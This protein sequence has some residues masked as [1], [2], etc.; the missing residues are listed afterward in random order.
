MLTTLIVILV[1]AVIG[2]LIVSVL[3][4]DASAKRIAYVLV[5]VIALIAASLALTGRLHATVK[6]QEPAH[7]ISAPTETR[8]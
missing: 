8:T 1:A 2:L 5:A 6:A 3:P 7:D 4:L